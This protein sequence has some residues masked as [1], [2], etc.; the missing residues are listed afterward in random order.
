[1][2]KDELRPGQ[3][4]CEGTG[5][6]LMSR[7]DSEWYKRLSYANEDLILKEK[8]EALTVKY[9]LSGL[10]AL[11]PG[12]RG[13]EVRIYKGKTLILHRDLN[14]SYNIWDF[15]LELIGRLR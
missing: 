11:A 4:V 2:T 12:L 8:F 5:G 13:T 9:S 3:Q 14:W 6:G 10:V 7:F 1:M 15:H